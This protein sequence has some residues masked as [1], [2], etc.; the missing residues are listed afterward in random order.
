MSDESKKS[1]TD[2]EFDTWLRA[3]IGRAGPSPFDREAAW[4]SLERKA[5]APHRRA[6]R[7]ITVTYPAAAAA[8]VGIFL[9]GIG[10]G[11]ILR[12]SGVS[13]VR[14]ETD[15]RVSHGDPSLEVQR[16]GS[17][18]VRAI[19][20]LAAVRGDTVE[21][22]LEV[23]LAALGGARTEVRRIDPETDSSAVEDRPG[24]NLVRF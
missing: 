24:A 11:T 4:R 9:G 14:R 22:G 20:E 15:S 3:R 6:R 16:T 19:S 10:A 18:F 7:R 12:D 5:H 8:L 2:D 13:S 21:A 17:A 1:M 23:A